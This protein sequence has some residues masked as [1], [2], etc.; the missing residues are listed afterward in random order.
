MAENQ[1]I[2]TAS[3]SSHIHPLPLHHG[4]GGGD[5]D[6]HSHNIIIAC[7]TTSTAQ[8]LHRHGHL[9]RTHSHSTS[10]AQ[11]LGVAGGDNDIHPRNLCLYC[12]IHL[13]QSIP[14]APRKVAQS[15]FCFSCLAA[16]HSK[17]WACQ[18][19]KA[20]PLLCL[21][22]SAWKPDSNQTEQDLHLASPFEPKKLQDSRMRLQ[23]RTVKCK[24]LTRKW[25]PSLL[26]MMPHP[27]IIS[28]KQHATHPDSLKSAYE[29]NWKL[30]NSM[31]HACWTSSWVLHDRAEAA[32]RPTSSIS[33]SRPR[34]VW[35]AWVEYVWVSWNSYSR[36]VG[37]VVGKPFQ[38]T[39]KALFNHYKALSN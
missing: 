35:V 26:S 27:V 2:L 29:Y 33:D 21:N 23:K 18:V 4:K 6:I 36:P 19:K 15:I 10:K 22:H 39:F 17:H 31:H 1:S 5:N 12:N 24:F 37:K 25:N 11:A 32:V 28:I 7:Y 34:A 20:P 38:T 3:Y 30:P 16:A 8:A 9:L 14:Q 13:W